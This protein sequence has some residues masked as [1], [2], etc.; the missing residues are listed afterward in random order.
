MQTG[1]GFQMHDLICGK[2]LGDGCLT[3][4]EGRKPRFQFSHTVKDKEWCEHCFE[5]LN[6]FLP[7]TPPKYRKTF[8]SRMV[9]GYTECYMVQ[10]RT[11]S[12]LCQ[13]YELWYP[14][15]KKELPLTY[16]EKHFNEKSLA[17]WYQDDGH[18]KQKDGIPKKIIFSTDSF[19]LKE[20]Y[21]LID[22]L[23][24]KYDLRFSIDAQNRLLL[25]DQFQII[26]LLKLIEPHTHKSMARKT[27]VPSEPKKIATR[28]TIYLPTDISLI[29]PTPEIN[30]QYKKLP[31]LVTLAE[32]AIEFS[33]FY[34]SFQKTLQTTKPYQIKINAE[35]QK[36]LSQLKVQTGLNLS[37][38]TALCFKL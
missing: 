31:K 37:Q 8:D 1:G 19:S 32:E 38:L 3:K 28:S 25:Y 20:N 17:W 13:L 21:F 33:K 15:S 9:S 24:R 34:I 23:Q 7:L 26:Y 10:S 6:S 22:F 5:Q 35:S 14:Q 11:S 16:I 2:L 30:E 18:F 29:K 36:I 27:L 12:E 4:Q